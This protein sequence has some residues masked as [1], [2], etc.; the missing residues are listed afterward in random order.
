M[1]KPFIPTPHE[2]RKIKRP[3]G[4][5]SQSPY[6]IDQGIVLSN[7]SVG[8]KVKSCPVSNSGETIFRPEWYHG[9][10]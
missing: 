4:W 8:R 2:T 5:P 6:H 9:N 10:V 3:L 7:E 1:S